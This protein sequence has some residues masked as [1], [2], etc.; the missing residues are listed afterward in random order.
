MAE[1][2][3]KSEVSYARKLSPVLQRRLCARLPKLNAANGHHPEGVLDGGAGVLDRAEDR[4][5]HATGRDDHPAGD[6]WLIM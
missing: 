1:L 4:G 3:Q 5:D 6:S 2:H